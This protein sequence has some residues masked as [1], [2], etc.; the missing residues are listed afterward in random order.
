MK[1]LD[2]ALFALALTLFLSLFILGCSEKTKSNDPNKIISDNGNMQVYVIERDIPGAGKLS[3]QDLQTISEKS[4][5]VLKNM[6][7]I[8]WMHSYVTDDKIYCVYSASD[9]NA[10]IAHARTGGFPINKI[11]AV[12]TMISPATAVR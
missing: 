3:P 8:K 11:S 12:H 10:L 7:G 2:V 4:C 5:G 6:S 9:T 1:K